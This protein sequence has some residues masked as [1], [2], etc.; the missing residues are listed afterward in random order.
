MH[1]RRSFLK[2][3]LAATSALSLPTLR[4]LAGPGGQSPTGLGPRRFIFIRKS[5][6]TFPSVYVPD[7]FSKTQKKAE[8]EKQA[9]EV[10]LDQHELPSW[11]RPIAA[12]KANLGIIQGLSCKMSENGHASYSSVMGAYNSGRNSL[13]GIKRATID[14][15]LA[16]LFPSPFGHVELTF[17]SPGGVAFNS[18][19]VAGYSAPAPHQRNFAYADPQTAYDELFKAAVNP[20]AIESDTA[21]LK[22]LQR[23]ESLQNSSMLLSL[24]S[25]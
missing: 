20:K 7:T 5:N 16:K 1:N 10:D 12:H 13:S 2:S 6:G 17:A 18:G 4:T 23:E 11:L 25:S 3:S 22:H 15:E 21:I 9:F 19:I 8:A 14:F 24:K